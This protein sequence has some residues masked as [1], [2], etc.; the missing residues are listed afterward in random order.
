MNLWL[1]RPRPWATVRSTG[2]HL[3]VDGKRECYTIELPW[4]DNQPGASCIPEGEYPISIYYSEKHKR[5]VMLLHDVPGRSMV[6]IHI[7][8]YPADLL[9]CIGVG[10]S[11]EVNAVYQS[12]VA[13]D[14]LFEKVKA[15][16]GEGQEV[17]IKISSEVDDAH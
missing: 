7:A 3:F 13:F 2:G 11:R 6:E 15:A 14:A 9:G 16:I 8:N 12:G 5:E 1:K 17:K 4:R 10:M